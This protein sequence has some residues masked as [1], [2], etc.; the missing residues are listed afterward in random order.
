[1]NENNT[2]LGSIRRLASFRFLERLPGCF[3]DRRTFK[4]A[5][6]TVL[7]RIVTTISLSRTFSAQDR[8]QTILSRH[9]IHT[10]TGSLRGTSSP[11]VIPRMS[12]IPARRSGRPK[13]PG[14]HSSIM[15][16][17]SSFQWASSMIFPTFP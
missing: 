5:F 13:F 1:M 15:C 6:L 8:Q 17:R 11:S 4:D 10:S 9:V 7:Y 14:V 16:S 12:L 2:I 3:F